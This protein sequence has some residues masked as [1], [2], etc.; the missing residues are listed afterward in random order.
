[1]GVLEPRKWDMLWN[2]C[3]DL[4][5]L[6]GFFFLLFVELLNGFG[7]QLRAKQRWRNWQLHVVLQ[8]PCL[9]PD[10]YLLMNFS[11]TFSKS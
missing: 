6:F 11:E 8:T 1:M 4:F 2:P 7:R 5:K 3:S 9:E 10:D